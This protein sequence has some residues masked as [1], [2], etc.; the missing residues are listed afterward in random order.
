MLAKIESVI[1]EVNLKSTVCQEDIEEVIAAVAA[2]V[3]D[4]K[5]GAQGQLTGRL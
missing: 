2:A 1:L 4:K 5:P 3:A